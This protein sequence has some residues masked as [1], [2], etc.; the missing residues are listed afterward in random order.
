MP[1]AGTASASANT[2]NKRQTMAVLLSGMCDP[3]GDLSI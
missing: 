3:D 1:Q 2:R